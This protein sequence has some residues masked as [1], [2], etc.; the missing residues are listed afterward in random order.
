[1]RNFPTQ[2]VISASIFLHLTSTCYPTETEQACEVRFARSPA[3]DFR[4]GKES[5]ILPPAED[6][7][8]SN[9]KWT[10]LSGKL[11]SNSG[12]LDVLLN[13]KTP[14]TEDDPRRNAFFAAGTEG[15]KM[16]LELPEAVDFHSL[17]VYSWHGSERAAQRFTAYTRAQPVDAA[18]LEKSGKATPAELSALGW[19]KIGDADT[20]KLQP[21]QHAVQLTVGKGQPAISCRQVLLD[22][23]TNVHPQG[24]GNTFFYEVDV[25]TTAQAQTG[26]QRITPAEKLTTTV[27]SKDKSLRVTLDFTA[28]PDLKPWMLETAIPELMN[29]YAKAAALICIPGKTPEAPKAYEILLKEGQLMPGRGGIPAYALGARMVVSSEFM[30]KERDNEALGCLIHEMV[31]IVQFGN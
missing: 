11:D 13:G 2:P 26:V 3:S 10:L 6:D 24:W 15:G 7:A 23:Q 12:G 31:H 4:F 14:N 5:A 16:L 22:V 25:L 8:G 20:S 1:M 28:S 27:E 30:R 29:W 18:E 21:G 17:A 19:V 9:G